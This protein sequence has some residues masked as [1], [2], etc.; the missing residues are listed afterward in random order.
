MNEWERIRRDLVVLDNGAVL[1]LAKPPGISV[2]GERHTTDL[3]RMAGEAGERLYPVHRIDK[4]TSGLVLFARDLAAHAELTRQFAR[5]TVDKLYLVVTRS[6]GLPAHGTLDLPLFT[7]SSG[8]VRIAAQRE[9]IVADP[10]QHRWFVPPA[11]TFS[12]TRS[13]PSVTTFAT[14]TGTADHTLLVVR[15]VTGRRH[16]IRVHLAW[17][18]HPIEGDPL[19]D[20]TAATRG[21]RTHLHSWRLTVAAP[22]AGGA[23]ARIEA[24]PDPEFWAP[25]SGPDPAGHTDLLDRIG[26]AVERVPPAPAAG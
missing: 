9:H 19:F 17:I 13:Y 24:P 23:P 8:R 21:A 22:W 5:R 11:E 14:V 1:A 26:R 4:V 2:M 3:V 18:G 6:V 12:H 7:A 25:L 10:D 16:Q 20:R 15:P